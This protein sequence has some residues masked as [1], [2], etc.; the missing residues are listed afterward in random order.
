MRQIGSYNVFKVVMIWL[1]IL[2][3]CLNGCRKSPDG[4]DKQDSDGSPIGIV[5][6]PHGS[7]VQV[8]GG[9]FSM[10][11]NNGK[12]DEKPVHSVRLSPFLIDR[13]EVTQEDFLKLMRKDPSHFKGSKRPVEQISWADAALYCNRRSSAEGFQPCYNEETGACDFN[14]NG[15]RLPTEAEWEYA[16]RANSTEAYCFGDNPKTLNLFAWYDENAN[17][18]TQPVGR[19]RPNAW[20]IYDMHGNVM[21]WCN[22]VYGKDYYANSIV[23]DPKGPPESV[24]SR[25]LLRGGAWNRQN[26][27]CRSSYRIGEYPGQLDGCFGRDDIGFR[28]VRK[29][30]QSL[31]IAVQN[32]ASEDR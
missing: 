9:Q 13:C 17:G 27:E 10:G 30:E 6:T 28:C 23:D 25:F 12:D 2:F 18:K 5:K 1:S 20:G 7:M 4:A 14:A 24:R 3:V 31:S 19:K 8:P 16:C 21:E 11:S 26:K 29:F 15:Y 32:Q 22:D